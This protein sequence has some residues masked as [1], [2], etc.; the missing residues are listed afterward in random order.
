MNK[1][2]NLV[3]VVCVVIAAVACML[4]WKYFI[5]DSTVLAPDG[6]PYKYS[7]TFSGDEPLCDAITLDC[8]YC[9]GELVGDT[10]YWND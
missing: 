9:E 8:G 1:R 5:Q 10:C 7:H 2:K 6:T 4:V 3:I